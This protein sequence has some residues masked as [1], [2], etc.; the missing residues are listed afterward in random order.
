MVHSEAY[1][2]SFLHNQ[3][4]GQNPQAWGQINPQ[5][6]QA[7]GQAFGGTGQQ[8]GNYGLGQAAFG[9]GGIQGTQFGQGGI[10]PWGQ[11]QGWGGTW[12]RQ[13][14]QQDVG[15]VVR[16]LLPL[17][18]QVL[19]QAQQPQ[20]AYG[21]GGFS[22]GPYGQGPRQLTQQ[23]VNEVV[24]QILPI[25]PQIVSLLQGQ[26]QHAAA[27]HGG[28][29]GY[30]WGGQTGQSGQSGQF[31]SF[32]GGFGQGQG[33]NPYAQHLLNQLLQQQSYGQFGGGIPP[34]QAAF[35]GSQS[36]GQQQR[37]LSQADVGEVTRQLA[38]VIPQV[39]ANLQAFNQQQQRPM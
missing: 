26:G 10:G 12:Q 28:G 14:S 22:Q 16:Q 13:L 4:W 34:F 3:Q 9:Q 15:E 7:L 32:A 25:V 6:A 35:G 21:Y 8:S 30:G 24:R 29:G 33:Q 27:I 37:Q 38:S 23:D 39:I 17:L 18:P 5:I 20:A 36:W 2:Q 11:P 19:S 1:P 31:G